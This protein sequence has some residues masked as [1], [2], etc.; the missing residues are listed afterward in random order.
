MHPASALV[1][2][3]AA[4]TAVALVVRRLR[5]PYTVALVLTGLALGV[6]HL[7]YGIHLTKDI[8]FSVFLPGL[9]FEAAYHLDFTEF[10]KSARAIFALA[11]PGVV[12]AIGATAA[13]L[14]V[15][16]QALG[17]GASLGWRHAL[18]FSAL[19]ATSCANAHH[20]CVDRRPDPCHPGTRF[21]HRARRQ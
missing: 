14:V 10:R 4:A 13:L 17:F 19:I 11:V 3:F 20:A 21:S 9:L 12:A 18:V 7:D 5:I 2:L 15:S 8:L 6:A 1:L 16:S